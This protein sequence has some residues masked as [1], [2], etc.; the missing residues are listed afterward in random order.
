[1]RQAAFF[2]HRQYIIFPVGHLL[3]QKKRTLLYLYAH[4]YQKVFPI[5]L[6]KN[7]TFHA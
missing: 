1:M 5:K 7:E 4:L 6:Q 2:C 3:L